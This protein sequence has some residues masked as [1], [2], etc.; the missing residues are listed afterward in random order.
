MFLIKEIT[1]FLEVPGVVEDGTPSILKYVILALVFLVLANNNE[2]NSS[3]AYSS[4][5]ISS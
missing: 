3:I 5:E 4:S 1:M 2:K